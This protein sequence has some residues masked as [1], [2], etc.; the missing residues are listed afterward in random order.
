VA[1]RNRGRPFERWP[2]PRLCP[3]PAATAGE[4]QE[5]ASR[6]VVSNAERL[7]ATAA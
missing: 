1:R 7:A 2:Q 6:Q 4:I 5:R 3:R